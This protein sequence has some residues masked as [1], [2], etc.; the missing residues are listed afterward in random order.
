MLLIVDIAS[1]RWQ[2]VTFYLRNQRNLEVA[3]YYDVGI[4]G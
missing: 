3:V 2:E 4:I 1:V